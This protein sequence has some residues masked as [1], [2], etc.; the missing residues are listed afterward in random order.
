MAYEATGREFEMIAIDRNES[1]SGGSVD[2]DSVFDR[3]Q[4]ELGCIGAEWTMIDA[5]APLRCGYPPTPRRT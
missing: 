2:P 1:L 3:V 5:M 4:E